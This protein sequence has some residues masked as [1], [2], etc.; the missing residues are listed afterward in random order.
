MNIN[1][2]GVPIMYGCGR[3]GVEEG[4]NSLREAG[5]IDILARNKR[6]KIYDMGNLYVPEVDKKDKYRSHN[7][8]KYL[9]PIME[10]NANLSHMVYMSLRSNSFPLVI[11]GD[12]SLGLGSIAGASRFYEN[13]AV[14]WIDAHGDINDHKTSPSGNIHGMSL[15]ASF[16]VGDPTLKNIYYEGAKVNPAHIYIVGVRDLDP[17]ELKL[18]K[19]LNLKLYTM[20]KVKKEG[21]NNILDGIIEDIKQSQVQ[22]V[23]LSFDIDALDES[24]VPGTGTSLTDGF[25]LEE[26]KI[27][28]ESLLKSRL[29][30]SMDL[31]EYN[32]HLDHEDM[33]TKRVCLELLETIEKNI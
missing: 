7:Q 24:I 3:A 13:I 2:I 28:I 5:M 19:K 10:V 4:P 17:G 8:M 21:L 30:T 22:G 16:G 25:N 9:D 11:G 32:P 29:I 27:I 15:A 23:H 14:I 31:V 12:H 26:G 6:N 1:I 33:P 18:A 20:E